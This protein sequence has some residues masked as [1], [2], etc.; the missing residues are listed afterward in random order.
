MLLKRPPLVNASKAALSYF[1]VYITD[2]NFL[3]S[4]KNVIFF[5]CILVDRPMGGGAI[6]PPRSLL[7]KLYW[8]NCFVF[9]CDFSKKKNAVI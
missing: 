3:E 2:K 8:I 4:A 9:W 5:L 6:A 7:A 1:R